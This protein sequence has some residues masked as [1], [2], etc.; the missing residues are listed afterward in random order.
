MNNVPF[1]W[2]RIRAS[3]PE[4]DT[5]QGTWRNMTDEELEKYN[6]YWLPEEEFCF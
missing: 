5:E 1:S 6:P 2:Q 3:L 4:D